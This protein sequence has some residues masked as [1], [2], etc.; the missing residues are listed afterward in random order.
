MLFTQ[1][2]EAISGRRCPPKNF[3]KTAEAGDVFL[4]D[5]DIYVGNSGNAG[6][7]AGISWLRR[8]LGPDY[9]VHEAPLS[10]SFLHM[11][12]VLAT[13][14]PGLALVCKAGFTKGIPELLKGWKLIEV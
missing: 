7:T 12:C 6:N 8:F 14:R 1:A 5:R 13:P 11:D 9:Q 2:L 3:E 10:K 4:L